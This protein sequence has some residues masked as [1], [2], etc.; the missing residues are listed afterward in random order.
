MFFHTTYEQVDF[1]QDY[2]RTF[3]ASIR[4]IGKGVLLV[5]TRCNYRQKPIACKN[6]DDVR[7]ITT[8]M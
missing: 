2:N 1:D 7:G 3:D 4:M 6:L 8:A 5:K